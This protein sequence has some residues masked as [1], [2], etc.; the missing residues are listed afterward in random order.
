M[1]GKKNGMGKKSLRVARPAGFQGSGL[2]LLKKKRGNSADRAH[3]PVIA[4]TKAYANLNTS[5]TK[6]EKK[7]N[8]KR[9]GQN[10]T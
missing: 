5:H 8:Y 4:Q 3:N 6:I 2:T 1:R 9:K 7:R 10:K